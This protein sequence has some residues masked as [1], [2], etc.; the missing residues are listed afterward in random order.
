MNENEKNITTEETQ[1]NDYIQAINDLKA[2]TVDRAQYDKLKAE[3]KRLLDSLVS[4]QTPEVAKPVEKPD[5]NELRK[6]L[7]NPDNNLSN[8]E[9]VDNMLKLRNALIDEGQ[10][11]PFLPIGEKVEVTV[12]TVN[13]AEMVANALQDCVDYAEGDSGI[14]TAQLQRIMKDNGPIKRGR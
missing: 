13:K 4:G 1:E 11:D 6:T 8:L 2:T 12:D 5:V 10:R 9:Y 7:F 3:N 14:F